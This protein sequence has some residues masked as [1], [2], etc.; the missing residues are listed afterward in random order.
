[1]AAAGCHA[2]T[3]A[4]LLACW[5]S[6]HAHTLADERFRLFVA[7][8]ILHVVRNNNLPWP[9]DHRAGGRR[10]GIHRLVWPGEILFSR[11]AHA[12]PRVYSKLPTKTRP[13]D[14]MNDISKICC[15]C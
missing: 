12:A 8:E 15:S 9:A 5:P 4:L 14:R 11:S 1:M 7:A 10:R 6:S 2:A 3:A 13:T